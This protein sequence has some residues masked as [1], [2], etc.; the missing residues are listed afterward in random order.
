[1]TLNMTINKSQHSAK[2]LS[3]QI[4]VMLSVIYARKRALYAECL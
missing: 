4:V 1:M 2:W 3:I